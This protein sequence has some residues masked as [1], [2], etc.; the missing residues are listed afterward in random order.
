M[1]FNE[2]PITQEVATGAEAVFRCRRPTADVIRWRVN[3]SLVGRN[4]PPDITPSIIRDDNGNS[5]DT[6]TITALPQYNGTEVVCVARFDD[7]RP[8]ELSQPAILIG[9][10][11]PDVIK[12]EL[13]QE[14]A[15]C[16][17][18]YAHCQHRQSFVQYLITEGCY[19]S[20]SGI[21]IIS[22]HSFV[23]SARHIKLTISMTI[24]CT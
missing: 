5:V 9:T 3:G 24:M 10:S 17:I 15:C 8:E 22:A 23:N 6:L 4:P 16:V 13:I 12:L 11:N 1:A 7:S 14:R 20:D 2:V 21:I 18:I 19:I